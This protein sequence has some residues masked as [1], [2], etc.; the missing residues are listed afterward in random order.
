MVI[1]RHANYDMVKRNSVTQINVVDVITTSRILK[2]PH[3]VITPSVAV[4]TFVTVIAGSP[5]YGLCCLA[6][7]LL[8]FF[9]PLLLLLLLL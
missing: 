6:A 9:V 7:V 5:T 1:E 3:R 2:P 4:D 8:V